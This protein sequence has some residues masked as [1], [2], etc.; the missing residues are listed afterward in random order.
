MF[1][2]LEEYGFEPTIISP[3]RKGA[4][5]DFL[6]KNVKLY[7]V[8]N[9]TKE[10]KE[11]D[12]DYLV[13]NSDQSWNNYN[14]DALSDHGYLRFAEFWNIPKFV[15]AASIGL[16]YWRY[17]KDFDKRA[18]ELIKNFSGLSVREIGAVNLVEQHLKIKPE[19]VLDPTFLIN[20]KYYLDL[21]KDLNKNF[22]YTKR[23]IFVYI[24]DE[25]KK[26]KKFIEKV[27]NS[28]NYTIFRVDVLKN[29]Y[30]TENFIFGINISD[31]IITDSFHGTVFSIIFNKPFI[32]FL[33]SFRGALRFYSLNQT[34]KLKDR[35]IKEIEEPNINKLIEPLNI[36]K[37]ILD[38][39][40]KKSIRYLEKNLGIRKKYKI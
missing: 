1:K 10:L 33:N 18:R 20:K 9:Y 3:T 30:Y 2:K 8:V 23:Y 19:F 7:E 21:I 24:L 37:K 12:F 26:K 31:A 22:D 16:D 11:E 39:M 5:I 36:D 28:L 4:N 13:V 40:M 34:F 17:S 14:L 27:K 32:S 29:K 6:H 38:I 25:N 15:Y 35:I